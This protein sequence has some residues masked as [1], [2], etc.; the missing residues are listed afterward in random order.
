MDSIGYTDN[1]IIR[2]FVHIPIA[3]NVTDT[4]I[5]NKDVSL[6]NLTLYGK[7]YFCRQISDVTNLHE[8]ET[9]FNNFIEN[10]T[11]DSLLEKVNNLNISTNKKLNALKVI[12]C[13]EQSTI[14]IDASSSLLQIFGLIMSDEKMLN[15]T[16]VLPND[17]MERNDIYIY[18]INILKIK[19]K[20]DIF[21]NYYTNRKIVKYTCM[22]YFYGSTA[23]YLSKDMKKKYSLKI[24]NIDL[25]V[26]TTNII[27]EFQ[28]EFPTISLGKKIINFYTSL[29]SQEKYITYKLHDKRLSYSLPNR[30]KVILS[31]KI[32]EQLDIKKVLFNDINSSQ[33]KLNINESKVLINENQIYDFYI[34]IKTIG[35]KTDLSKRCKSALVNIIHSFDSQICIKTRHML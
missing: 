19:Y 2:S 18:L 28:K 12:L 7:Y 33:E 32:N 11:C 1:K 25:I 20:G 23:K 34:S 27:K 29:I 9:Y 8:S 16:N 31:K 4:S 22:T 24:L 3:T 35:N 13:K 14:S 26:I 30:S 5:M 21:Y 10:E 17:N 15:L 6:N